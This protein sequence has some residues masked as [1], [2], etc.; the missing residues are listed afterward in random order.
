M[1][2]RESSAPSLKVVLRGLIAEARIGVTEEERARPQRLRLDVELQVSP[3]DGLGPDFAD[4]IETVLDYGLLRERLLRLCGDN[5]AKL[6]E[7]LADRIARDCLADSRVRHARVRI[8]K[9][10][11]F[12]GIEGIGVEIERHASR[13]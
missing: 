6:L 13:L 7:T 8:E 5:R 9:P 10:D 12:S 1:T 2:S 4:E 3:P 11:I